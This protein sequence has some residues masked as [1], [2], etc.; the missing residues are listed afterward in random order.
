MLNFHFS[1]QNNFIWTLFADSRDH[2][3]KM[4]INEISEWVRVRYLIKLI[5]KNSKETGIALYKTILIRK[6]VDLNHNN[7]NI[8]QS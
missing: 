1:A 6:K 8:E 7:I 5:L 3:V 4:W 2:H